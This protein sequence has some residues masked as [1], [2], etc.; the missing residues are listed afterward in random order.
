MGDGG[1]VGEDGEDD[2]FG[3]SRGHGDGI[4]G[5]YETFGR[6][7][8]RKGEEKPWI[9]ATA[10]CSYVTEQRDRLAAQKNRQ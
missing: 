6:E 8:E 9:Q 1:G 5:R 3:C 4:G 10:R 7:G 2:L